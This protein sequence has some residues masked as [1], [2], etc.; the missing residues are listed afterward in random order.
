MQI[1]HKLLAAAAIMV[2]S[3]FT[4]SAETVIGYTNGEIGK[5]TLFRCGMDSRQGMAIKLSPSKL[6]ALQGQAITSVDLGIGSRNT[7]SSD[8]TVQFFIATSL[9]ATPLYTQDLAI[10]SAMLKFQNHQLTTPYVITGQEEALY[11]GYTG[12]FLAKVTPLHADHSTDMRDCSFA[13]SD[14]QWIDMFGMGFGSADIRLNLQQDVAF[15]DVILSDLNLSDN[16]YLADQTYEHKASIFNFG[17][18]PITSLDVTVSI[19]GQTNTM[20]YDGLNIPQAS[21]YSI[22]LPALSCSQANATK[23]VEISVRA[24]GAD[25]ID[26]ADNTCI[27]SAFFYPS[28]M[29]RNILIE[30]FTGMGCKNCPNGKRTLHEGIKQSGLPCVEIM[31]HSG[32]QPDYLSMDTDYD[33]TIFYGG[34]STFAPAMM[35][36][37]Q[38]YPSLS[39]IAM[40]NVSVPLVTSAMQIA[41]SRQP[42]VSLALESQYDA[43]TRQVKVALQIL[44]HNIQSDA[45]LFNAYLIQDSIIGNQEGAPDPENYQHDGCLRRVLTGNSW[46]LLLPDDFTPGKVQ[47]WNHEFVLPEAIV[48]DLYSEES[49]IE[50]GL[51][52]SYTFATDPEHMRIVVYVA[53]YDDENINNNIVYNCIEIPLVNGRCIQRGIEGAVALESVH[54]DT[55]AASSIITDLAGRRFTSQ[56]QLSA[57]FYIINGKKTLICR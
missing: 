49:I 24:N 48:S 35:V 30:E 34:E 42:Y 43:E 45:V 52:D 16:Y 29:E 5:N 13:L 28:D 21:T 12:D 38:L 36:N 4:A 1:T 46:G 53:N 39:N 56:T 54:T 3:I 32:Y 47:V 57:G 51:I 7:K 25:E 55:S 14:G 44:N 11:I 10:T 22:A 6:Q 40:L 2:T 15:T 27:A 20:T 9:D 33:Y 19:D 37:R 31:H 26:M 23:D 50:A 18:Q 8:K 17:T 41:S